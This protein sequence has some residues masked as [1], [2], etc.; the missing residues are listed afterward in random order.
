MRRSLAVSTEV[1][2]GVVLD[3]IGNESRQSLREPW[4]IGQQ[5]RKRTASALM[6]DAPRREEAGLQG[7][8][9]VLRAGSRSALAKKLNRTDFWGRRLAP[10]EYA[11]VV[12]SMLDAAEHYGIVRLVPTVFERPGWRLA[13]EAVRFV[14]GTGRADGRNPNAYFTRLYET[15]ADLLM[16][17]GEGLF[18]FEGREHTAQVDQER[19]V[20]R[21]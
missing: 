20:W 17:G 3:Q 2:D 14:A 10:D 4:T 18:G 11:S 16:A 5:E 8:P 21:E 19:R 13:A 7:E 15:L 6:I 1:L 9:L 12:K